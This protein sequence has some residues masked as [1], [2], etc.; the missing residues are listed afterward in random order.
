MA[1]LGYRLGEDGRTLVP[2]ED[3]QRVLRILYDLRA[4]GA[5]LRVVSDELNRLGFRTR[6]GGRWYRQ[7]VALQVARYEERDRK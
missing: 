6:R 4:A 2:H 7:Y 1:P 3:E 5:N